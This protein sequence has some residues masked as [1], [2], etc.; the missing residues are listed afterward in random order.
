MRKYIEHIKNTRTPHE[1]RTHALQAASVI[2]AAIFVV[3]IGTL[4]LRLGTGG[5]AVA[6]DDGTQTL[7]NNQTSLSASAAAATTNNQAHLEVSTTSVYS[8]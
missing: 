7:N 6:Q 5:A 3:W 8:N 4:G 2:T 1:R